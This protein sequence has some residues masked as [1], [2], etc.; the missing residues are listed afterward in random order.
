MNRY[1]LT[2]CIWQLELK[3]VSAQYTQQN[4]TNH[5]VLNLNYKNMKVKSKNN[6]WSMTSKHFSYK[7]DKI[8]HNNKDL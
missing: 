1:K 2:F 8:Q 6:N 5:Y 4:Q 3:Y 7:M